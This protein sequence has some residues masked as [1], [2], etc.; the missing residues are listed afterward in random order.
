MFINVKY[1]SKIIISPMK[2]YLGV[3]NRRVE[4]LSLCRFI[5]NSNSSSSSSS[6]A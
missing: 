6:K 3:Q 1:L 2:T 5:S 4:I